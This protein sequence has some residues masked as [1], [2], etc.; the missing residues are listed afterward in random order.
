MAAG[1]L[2]GME[3]TAFIGPYRF[4]SNFWPAT[5]VLDGETYPTVA[6]AYQAAKTLSA[7]CRAQI[8]GAETAAQARRLGRVVPRRPDW[9]QVKLRMMEELLRQKFSAGPL[10]QQLAATGLALLVEGNTWG[11]VYWGVCRGRG[12]NH[13]GR[14]LMQVREELAG[15]R[16]AGR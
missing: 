6:H 2:T 16:H 14:L 4:L 15:V 11:D 3:I 13:L 5:V 8:R 10:R 7:E 1:R 12:E 9:P